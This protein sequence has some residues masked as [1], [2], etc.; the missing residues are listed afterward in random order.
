MI[1]VTFDSDHVKKMDVKCIGC[2]MEPSSDI[3]EIF[4]RLERYRKEKSIFIQVFDAE[5][6]IGKDH[7]IWAYDKALRNFDQKTNRADSLEIE[8]LLWSSGKRQ[9]KNAL[10]KMGIKKS[11][12]NVAILSDSNISDLLS[13]MGWEKDDNVL[14]P[15]KEKLEKHDITTEEIN[16]VDEPYDLIYEKMSLSIL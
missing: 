1:Y 12:K 9:I 13:D 8:T 5:M 15:S 7:L 2:K 6:I 16:S 3:D 4:E 11:S 10:N 14:A